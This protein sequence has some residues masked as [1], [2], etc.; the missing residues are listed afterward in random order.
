M[1]PLDKNFSREYDNPM[2]LFEE[3]MNELIEVIWPALDNGASVDEV[4]A[5]VTNAIEAWEPLNVTSGVHA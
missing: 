2:E 5:A 4:R 1:Q 3:L